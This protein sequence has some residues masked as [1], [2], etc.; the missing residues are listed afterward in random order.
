MRKKL[1]VCSAVAVLGFCMKAEAQ[2]F[3]RGYD[4]ANQ[5][6]F[7]EKGSWM[8]GGTGSY[9]LLNTKDFSFMVADGICTSAYGLSVSPAFCY[10]V[11][12][13]LGVGLRLDYDRSMVKLDNASLGIEDMDLS[14]SDYHTLNHS[15]EAKILL[16]N[17]IP[18]AGSR[19]FAM[20]NET[21]L[22]FGYGQGKVAD[23]HGIGT[24]GTF[25]TSRSAGLFICPGLMAFASEHMA[26]EVSMNMLGLGVTRTDQIHNQ[27]DT[28]SRNSTIFNF[29]INVLSVGFGIYYYL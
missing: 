10:M 21:Q 16:R 13:N 7:V 12:D 27:V 6:V 18:I 9:N 17:Y 19:R 2:R 26:V 15:F 14:V 3:E 4:M 28:G 25:E 22:A 5:P 29:K 8:V 20:V 23:S 1:I 11:R 24:V